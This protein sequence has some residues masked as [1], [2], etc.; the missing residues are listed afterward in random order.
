[1]RMPVAKGDR[2]MKVAVGR[3]HEHYCAGCA[4]KFI[5]KAI[6]RLRKLDAELAD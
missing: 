3:S 5:Q 4:R 1:M 6:E 2:R